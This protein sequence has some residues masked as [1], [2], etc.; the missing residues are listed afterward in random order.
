MTMELTYLGQSAFQFEGA[1]GTRLLIDPWI[2]DN[3]HCDRDVE[4]FTDVSAVLVTHAAFDHLGD[5][6]EI[7]RRNEATLVCDYVTRTALADRGFPTELLEGYV[8][9]AEHT[10]EGWSAKVV[11]ARHQSFDS[12]AGMI[13]PALAYVI[14]IDGLSIYHM[15]DT[16]IFGDIKLF[17]EL[18]E[19]DVSLVP[20]GEAPGYFT[21][22]HPDEAALAAGWLGSDLVVPM[23]YAPGSDNPETFRRHCEELGVV[24]TTEIVPMTPVSDIEL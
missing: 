2:E 22:L 1:G 7:A 16:S 17:A 14:T 15:G 12:E 13:G 20:V 8:W 4:S 6:P 19:P 21:E 9:G 5:A 11:E 23:H 3:P 18:Y 24:E 10:G